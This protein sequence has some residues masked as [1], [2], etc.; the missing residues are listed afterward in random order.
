MEQNT[1]Q[2]NTHADTGMWLLA[3]C[4]ATDGTEKTGLAYGDE[5]NQVTVS[6]YS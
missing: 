3:I 6:H 2:E 4:I 1:G 5:W